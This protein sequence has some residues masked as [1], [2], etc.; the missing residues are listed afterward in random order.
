MHGASLATASLVHTLQAADPRGH[1]SGAAVMIC[2]GS[3][4]PRVCPA[5]AS[6][7]RFCRAQAQHLSPQHLSRHAVQE[8]GCMQ[9]GVGAP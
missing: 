8:D 3:S 4:A 1:V 5:A 6:T 7:V 2:S 9:K